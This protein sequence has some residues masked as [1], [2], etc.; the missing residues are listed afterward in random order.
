MGKALGMKVLIAERK[1]SSTAREGRTLF[2]EVLE[3]CTV[4][5]M[6]CPLDSSTRNM[7]DEAELRTMKDDAIIVNVGR[8]GIIN[9]LALATALKERRI[10]GAAT[11]VFETEP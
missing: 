7:I 6:T 4:L 8:G 10:G 2:E 3:Q 5:I 11:D 1:G 9:E